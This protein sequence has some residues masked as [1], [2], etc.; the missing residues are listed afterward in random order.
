MADTSLGFKFRGRR[1][2]GS[3]TI[4]S[5][6]CGATAT[7][8][9]G[10]LLSLDSSGRVILGVTG[11]TKFVGVCRETK[12]GTINVTKYEVITDEDA[13]YAVYDNNARVQ[14]ATLDISGTTG[15][16]TVAT[17]S[18]KEFVVHATKAAN[19][20]ETLVQFNFG[21]HVFNTAL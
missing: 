5:I 9:A 6:V 18:N 10:D 16:Q 17:S 19:S 1:S 13:I 14:G 21:K 2:G 12:A 8:S 7:L 4:R 11:A 3:A 15:A 20:D